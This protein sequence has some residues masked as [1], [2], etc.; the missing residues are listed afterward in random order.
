MSD[1]KKIATHDEVLE[2]LTEQA[3]NG[4]VT[5]AA[6]LERALRNRPVDP[7]AE[8]DDVLDRDSP[9]GERLAEHAARLAG[10]WRVRR[11]LAG[12]SRFLDVRQAT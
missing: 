12:L 10:P 11:R 6:A 8:I 4:S 1:E 3:R 2:M 7:E 9:Q 5:A